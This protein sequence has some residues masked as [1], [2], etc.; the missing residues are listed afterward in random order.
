M[1]ARLAQ[2]DAFIYEESFNAPLPQAG[3]GLGERE[4]KEQKQASVRS[5]L[6]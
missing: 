3:E 6:T 2:F 4:N 1:S 5:L